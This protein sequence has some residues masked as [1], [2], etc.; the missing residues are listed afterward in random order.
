MS[1]WYVSA[2]QRSASAKVAA[3]TGASMNSWMST[4]LSACAPPLS[5]FMSGIGSTG[6]FVPPT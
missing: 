2:P 5:T 6:A 4:L 1:A 3:P